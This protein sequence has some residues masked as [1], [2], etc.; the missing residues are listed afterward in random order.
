MIACGYYIHYEIRD[1]FLL[2][3]IMHTTY[4]IVKQSIWWKIVASP[5]HTESCLTCE[6]YEVVRGGVLVILLDLR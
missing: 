2:S 6:K 4:H 1:Y 5:S 3:C